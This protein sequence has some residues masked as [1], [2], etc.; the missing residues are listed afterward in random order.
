MRSLLN[1][2]LSCFGRLIGKKFVDY[3]PGPANAF[4]RTAV[5]AKEGFWYVGN[6]LDKTDIAYGLLNNGVVEPEE[7]KLVRKILKIILQK[8]RLV[9]YDIGANTGYYGILAA[10]MGKDRAKV[11]SF[12]PVT[13]HCECLKESV[14]LNRLEDSLEVFKL[15]LSDSTGEQTFYLA[16]SGSSLNKEFLLGRQLETQN[17]KVA[18]LDDVVLEKELFSPDFIKIDVE[19]NEFNVLK[20][21]EQVIK[22]ALPMLFVEIAYNLKA[23]N[24]SFV[25]EYFEETFEF[26]RKLGY[27]AYTEGENGMEERGQS[28]KPEGVKM[29]LFLHL[30]KHA[31][32]LHELFKS[33]K[34]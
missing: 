4:G 10:F 16:G 8:G 20:G 19:G 11:Y 2:L 15:A 7:T 32:V 12:E 21:S 34:L 33:P 9:F 23:E 6:V 22:K 30:E 3:K 13:E 24:K 18:R 26:L 25:N 5:K 29:Y 17:V 1:F 28:A 27:G 14:C 31:E